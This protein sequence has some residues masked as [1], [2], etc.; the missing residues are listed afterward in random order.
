VVSFT[1]RP[2]YP[3]NPLDRKL[4]HGPLR[5]REWECGLD[6]SGSGYRTAE[7]SRE[8]NNELLDSINGEGKFHDQLS[9]YRLLKKDSGPWSLLR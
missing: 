7:G 9:D 8:N 5:N 4:G 6:S 1:T 3:R 2:L